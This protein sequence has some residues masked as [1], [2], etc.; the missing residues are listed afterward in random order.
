MTGDTQVTPPAP[1]P[2][3]RW[4]VLFPA[5]LALLCVALV[6]VAYHYRDEYHD[7]ADRYRTQAFRSAGLENDCRRYRELLANYQHPP[8]QVE[9]TMTS[10]ELV[11]LRKQGLD[12]PYRAL[13][14]DL[15]SNPHFENLP[16]GELDF[17]DAEQVCV[18]G[19]DRV[20]ARYEGIDGNGM[21]LLA[22]RVDDRGGVAWRLLERFEDP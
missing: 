8:L 1:E 22:Y 12:D 11:Q 21:A 5:G 3:S 18:L 20:V 9:P 15:V 17:T 10:R 6:L 4:W 13:A 7:L 2:P 19:P 16:H 14:E